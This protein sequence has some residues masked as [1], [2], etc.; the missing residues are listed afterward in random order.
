[1]KLLPYVGLFL[2]LG[3][4]VP[5]YLGYD[6][7]LFMERA[8]RDVEGADVGLQN[9]RLSPEAAAKLKAEATETIEKKSSERN[10]L[11]GGGIAGLILGV[12]VA[13]LTGSRK[14]KQPT[15]A[16]D[17]SVPPP[18]VTAPPPM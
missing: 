2:A 10:F 6:A 16:A 14:R 17:V 12:G 5:V 7:H 4:L 11:I 1:M 18:E 8:E 9:H 15:P 13:G 3:S